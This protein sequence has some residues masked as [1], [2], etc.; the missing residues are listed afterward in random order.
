MVSM[1]DVT[2]SNIKAIGY[3]PDTKDLR[4]AYN[5]G[6]YVYGAV[7]ASVHAALMASPSKGKFVAKS[8]KGKFKAAKA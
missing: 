6:V 2:S 3:D 1:T 5:S 8:I 4:I 7:P